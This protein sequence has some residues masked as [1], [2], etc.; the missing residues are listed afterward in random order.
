MEPLGLGPPPSSRRPLFDAHDHL[1]N[2]PYP[3]Q[4]QL[5]VVCGTC[6]SDW[7]A[8][9]AQAASDE[10][11]IPMLGLHPWHVG[12]ASA[13]W[14]VR[15][16]SLLRSHRAGVGECGLDFSRKE[17]DRANQE[18]AFRIQLRLAH[19]LHRPLAMHVVHAWGRLLALLNEEGVPAAGAMV[20]AYSGSPEM[21]RALQAMGVFLS[22]SGL[23]LKADRAKTRELL[24]AVDTHC[25]LLETDGTG[26]LG[27]VLEAAAGIRGLPVAQ[28]ATQTGENG[29]RC[30]KELVA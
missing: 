21:A 18:S 20:H 4:N 27:A 17:E 26:D 3:H 10:E 16:E 7:E 11:I 30:F 12:E 28:L 13:H 15:L 8:I 14:N 5:R 29:R 24:L 23:L 25:L 22:F 9:L 1:R 2:A 6:E 19:T